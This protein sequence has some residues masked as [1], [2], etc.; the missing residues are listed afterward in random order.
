MENLA[1]YGPVVILTVVVLQL[2][3]L[4]ITLVKERLGNKKADNP[5]IKARLELIQQS[6][7]RI[8]EDVK[9]L[10][11][12]VITGNGGIPLTTEVAVLSQQVQ[13]HIADRGLHTA[14]R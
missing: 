2:V 8:E 13:D 7:G 4:V 10:K 5:G 14:E 9:L 12:K 1:E 6:A 3:G 11:R